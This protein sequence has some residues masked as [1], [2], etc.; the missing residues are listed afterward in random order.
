MKSA[1]LQ[2]ANALAD[3]ALAQG[4]ADSAL[5]QLAD[6][7][8]AFAI[9]PE[10][11]N[12]LTSP[13]VPR[14]A[15]HA[16]IEKISARVGVGKIIRNFLFV[17]ADHQRTHILP[18]IIAAFEGVIRRRQGIAEAEISSAVELSTAQ[19]KR[20]AQ[21]LERLTGKKIQAKYSLDPALLGG[22]VVRVGDTVYDGSVRNSLNELRA[23]LAAQ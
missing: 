3:V 5:K 17:I 11:R 7:G 21:T 15:K 13:A 19:K 18:E 6:F 1:S 16:V 8:A 12:F 20:F 22:A 14:E 4:A 23:R 9:S 10:L 2:Y